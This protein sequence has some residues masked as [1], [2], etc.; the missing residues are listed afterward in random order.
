MTFL[1]LLTEQE[2]AAWHAMLQRYAFYGYSVV[3]KDNLLSCGV[4]AMEKE[5]IVHPLAEEVNLWLHY[6]LE[7]RIGIYVQWGSASK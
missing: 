3:L 7:I 5:R 6:L 1:W 2:S 4:Y